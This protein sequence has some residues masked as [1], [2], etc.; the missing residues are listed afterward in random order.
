MVN[1]FHKDDEKLRYSGR[2][3]A[4]NSFTA[5]TAPLWTP[6]SRHSAL[7]ARSS[8][9]LAA[10]MHLG[11]PSTDLPLQPLHAETFA[12]RTLDAVGL[13]G[14]KCNYKSQLLLLRQLPSR[15]G[16]PFQGP[17]GS[18]LACATAG[19][20]CDQSASLDQCRLFEYT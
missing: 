11:A 12:C 5:G 2:G 19:H 10:S 4:S 9:P 17:E 6:M 3:V 13:R 14:K 18:L 15:F 8:G 1:S 20:Q 16:A 7:L